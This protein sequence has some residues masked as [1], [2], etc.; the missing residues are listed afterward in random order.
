MISYVT[1][2]NF[3]KANGYLERLLEVGKF[4]WLNKYGEK[5]VK[6]LEE[7]TPVRTGRL[8]SSWYYKIDHTKDGAILSWNN[9]DIENGEN[10]AIVVMNGHV[11]KNGNYIAPNDF[12]TPALTQIFEEIYNSI[13]KEVKNK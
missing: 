4:G 13:E 2:G 9:Y 1:H 5:G 11:T 6:A 7:S 10:I 12:V 3:K 8:A